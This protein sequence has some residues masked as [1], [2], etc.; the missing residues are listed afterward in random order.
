MARSTF[1]TVSPTHPGADKTVPLDQVVMAI[2]GRTLDLLTWRTKSAIRTAANIRR[3]RVHHENTGDCNSRT[4]IAE[5]AAIN[6]MTASYH[7]SITPHPTEGHDA[8]T[9][10]HRPTSRRMRRQAPKGL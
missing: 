3:D 9:A 10:H 4:K 7:W 1:A 6:A 8:S 5:I 2:V